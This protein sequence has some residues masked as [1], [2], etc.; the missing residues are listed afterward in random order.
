MLVIIITISE[1][2]LL[3]RT[4]QQFRLHVLVILFWNLVVLIILWIANNSV[5][6]L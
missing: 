2:S 5:H 4:H 1:K 3:S 6:L